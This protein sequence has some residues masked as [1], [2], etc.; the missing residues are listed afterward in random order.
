MHRLSAGCATAVMQ[1]PTMC[2]ERRARRAAHGKHT[3]RSQV[4]AWPARVVRHRH[5]CTMECC[6]VHVR[7]YCSTRSHCM[8]RQALR[9]CCRPCY[10]TLPAW[11][12]AKVALGHRHSNEVVLYL[13]FC[14]FVGIEIC[15]VL[16]GWGSELKASMCSSTADCSHSHD[17]QLTIQRAVGC[18]HSIASVCI[19]SL[20]T[21]CQGQWGTGT[22][23]VMGSEIIACSLHDCRPINAQKTDEVSEATHPTSS[24]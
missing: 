9:W 1:G 3:L 24:S 14:C 20:K 21:C 10:S 4:Q 17:Q 16:F 2:A 12:P 23:T 13:V 11:Q 6:G 22:I 15:F 5:N 8:S 18:G 7:Q 19:R